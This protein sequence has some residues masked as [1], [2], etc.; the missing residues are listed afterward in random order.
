MKKLLIVASFILLFLVGCNK[1]LEKSISFEQ[2]ELKIQIIETKELPINLQNVD[3]SEIIFTVQNPEVLLIEGEIMLPLSIGTTEVTATLISDN[4]ITATINVNV[5][6]ELPNVR[7]PETIEIYSSTR[8][9]ILNFENNDDFIWHIEDSTIVELN[10]D[11]NLSALKTGKTTL[12]VTNKVDSTISNSFEIEVLDQ[13]P[14]IFAHNT[15]IEVGD[16]IDLEILN[17]NGNTKDDFNWELSDHELAEISTDYK[18]TALKEGSLIITTTL[19]ND[20]RVTNHIEIVIGKAIIGDGEVTVG[21]LFLK[22]KNSSALV[23]AGETIDIEIVGAKDKYNYRWLSSDAT[24]VAATDQGVIHGIKEG[25]AVITAFSKSDHTVRG[26]ITVTVYGVANVN[27]IE[28][29]I[30]AAL[31]EEGYREG[32]NSDN[33]FGDWFM[34]N[35]ADWCAMFVSWSANQAGIGLDVIHKFSLVSDGVRWF[36]ERGLYHERGEY[37]PKRGDIIFFISGSRPS[38]VGIVVSVDD[39]RVY[40][41]EGNTSNS[42]AQ[43]SYLLTN[44]YVMGYGAPDYPDFTPNN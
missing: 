12:T 29:L 41:I 23:K 36:D 3:I 1:D 8:L 39:E 15:L 27:Y 35:N 2:S 17:I 31:S 5:T 21:P 38:H 24:I 42:V 30:A 33:K 32:Y 44:P 19:K 11:Y 37:T 20:S 18:L 43:R 40:T 26:Y 28:R 7:I 34:Y 13:K 4:N 25:Q 10:S 9:I 14:Q 6:P 22:A 16:V